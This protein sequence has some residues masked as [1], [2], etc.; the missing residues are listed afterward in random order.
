MRKHTSLMIVALASV[1]MLAGCTTRVVTSGSGS[2]PL[3]TVTAQGNGTS[4]AAPDVAE[5]SF[6]VMVQDA[7][8]KTALDKASATAEM[9]ASAVKKA[10]VRSQDIQTAN[11][12]L[13]PQQD[14]REGQAPVILGYEASISVRVKVRDLGD[15][16]DVITAAT[17]AGANTINGP[18]FT[19][20]DDEAAREAA[21]TD[22]VAK[23]RV[24]A[25]AMAE[26]A[27]KRLGDVIA[28]SETGVSVPQIYYGETAAAAD[29]A[30]SVPIEPGELDVTASVTVVFELK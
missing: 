9:I 20:D 21:I 10:G 6:G 23:A 16:G 19:L 29:M 5:M 8:A 4:A 12:N 13:Y 15:V 27:D 18:S 17:T 3:N 1:L 2:T 22:A 7:D 30:L 26:A 24:R 14:Y 11:V 28:I 25:E